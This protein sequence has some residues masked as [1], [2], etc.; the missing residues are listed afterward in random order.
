MSTDEHN[1]FLQVGDKADVH[2]VLIETNNMF[3]LI[4]ENWNFQK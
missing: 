3:G 4:P 1:E 2:S